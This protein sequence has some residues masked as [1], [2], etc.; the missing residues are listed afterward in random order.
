MCQ[1]TLGGPRPLAAIR[2]YIYGKG[3]EMKIGS[4]RGRREGEGRGEGHVAS[5]AIL[6]PG[7]KIFEKCVF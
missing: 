6:G 5:H 2:T 1:Y 4:M 3:G 7:G